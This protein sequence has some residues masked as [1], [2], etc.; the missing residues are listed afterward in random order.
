LRILTHYSRE[1]VWRDAF[2]SKPNKDVHSMSAQMFRREL[3]DTNAVEGCAFFTKNYKKCKCPVHAEVRNRYKAVTLGVIMGKMKWSLAIEMGFKDIPVLDENGDPVYEKVRGRRVP[4]VHSAAD[5]AGALID[6]WFENFQHNR[7]AIE[8]NQHDMY[9]SGE[10][11]T[12][13]DRRRLVDKVV[14]DSDFE[15]RRIGVKKYP[16]K[17]CPWAYNDDGTIKETYVSKAVNGLIAAKM[18]EAGNVPYQGTGADQMKTAM[19]SGHDKNGVPFMWHKLRELEEKYGEDV[20]LLENY[21][22]DE[23]LVECMAEVAE[24]VGGVPDEDGVA[25]GGIISDCIIR[26]GEVFIDIP[27][28]SEGAVLPY[29]SK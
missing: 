8:K 23:F 7:E 26:S 10:A 22:Y 21:V 29:W 11:R 2:C 17:D 15:R 9:H 13:G 24:E 1:P 28:E 6:E 5:Q 3:W 12:R 27:M 16:I 20:A 4:V 18:R 19:G 25:R 14:E